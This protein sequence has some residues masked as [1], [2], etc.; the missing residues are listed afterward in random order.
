MEHT[1]RPY[2]TAAIIVAAGRG[3]RAGA[4]RPKQYR[5]LA[6]GIASGV[7][8]EMTNG[9]ANEMAADTASAAGETVLAR[10][11]RRFLDHP[12]IDHVQVVIHADDTDLYAETRAMLGEETS[13]KLL[14]PTLGGASRQ[15]SVHAGLLALGAHPPEFVLIHDAARPFV[16]D[17]LIETLCET[18]AGGQMTGIVPTCPIT[19]TV[20]WVSDGRIEKTLPRAQLARAQTP[21]IFR[22][23]PLAIAHQDAHQDK[24]SNAATDDA[25]LLE[26][27]G[28]I[29]TTLAGSEENIKLTYENDFMTHDNRAHAPPLFV[30]RTGLGFDVHRLQDGNKGLYLCGIHINEGLELIGHSDADVGLHALTDALLALMALGDIG[31]HFPPSD[32]THRDRPSSEFVAFAMQNLAAHPIQLTHVDVTLIC[33]QP[34]I[35]PHREP[36]RDRLAELLALPRGQISIKATTT[37]GLGF[38]GRGEGIAAQVIVSAMTPTIA[39]AVQG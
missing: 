36:M 34:K 27:R 9:A 17:Q 6:G 12:H 33:E 13:S 15:A 8:D 22:F 5:P 24:A 35:S 37:E 30:P 16:S 31:V 26:E 19:D 21:Q 3:H 11:L 18:L 2:S 1:Q 38:T 23:A 7:A 29:I 4:G 39:R 25:A 32:P 28:A 10:T 20:K 14:P